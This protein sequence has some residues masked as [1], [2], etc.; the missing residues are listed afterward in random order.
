MSVVVGFNRLIDSQKF[1]VGS[2]LQDKI[3]VLLV[4]I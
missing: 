3:Q 1:K 2:V 4:L